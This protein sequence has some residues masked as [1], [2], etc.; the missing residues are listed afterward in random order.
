MAYLAQQGIVFYDIAG[1]YTVAALLALLA[2]ETSLLSYMTGSLYY[3][4]RIL[5]EAL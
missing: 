1:P 2:L 5:N 4:L 3:T